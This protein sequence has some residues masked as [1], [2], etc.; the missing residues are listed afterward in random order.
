MRA[1]GASSSP[2]F[3]GTVRPDA[4]AYLASSF[5]VLSVADVVAVFD[6]RFTTSTSEH[7][8]PLVVN[9]VL[10]EVFPACMCVCAYV[11]TYV[12]MYVCMYVRM[13]I[14]SVS[15]LVVNSVLAFS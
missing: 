12:C 1:F 5:D 2:F 6:V 9:S 11:R 8:S 4:S 15:P 10:P 7:F 3:A 14:D 13:H